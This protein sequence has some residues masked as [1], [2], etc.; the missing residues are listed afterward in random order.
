MRKD[1]KHKVKV[2]NMICI[3]TFLDDIT[4]KKLDQI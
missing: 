1:T 2:K 3:Q 4:G